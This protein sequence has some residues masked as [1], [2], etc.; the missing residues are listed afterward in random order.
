[1]DFTRP[2]LSGVAATIVGTIG[3]ALAAISIAIPQ[4]WGFFVGLVGF[5]AA[6]LAGMAS[7]PPEV[8][9]GSPKLQGTALAIATTL[10]GLLVQYWPM[11]PVGWPQSVAMVVAAVVSWLTGR[12]LPQLGSTSIPTARIDLVGGARGAADLFNRAG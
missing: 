8:V 9:E 1:M 2:L 12:A 10:G 4:P 7:R 11:I 5:L 3:L 6:A